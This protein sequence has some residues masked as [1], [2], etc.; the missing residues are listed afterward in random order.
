M[1]EGKLESG[2]F[3]GLG[4]VKRQIRLQQKVLENSWKLAQLN[5]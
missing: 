1:K 2:R 4:N 3:K 5:P